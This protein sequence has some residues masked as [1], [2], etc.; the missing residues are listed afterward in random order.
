[1]GPAVLITLG[2]LFL[3]SQVG[4]SYWLNF[5]RTWPALLIVIGLVSFLKHSASAAGHVP[6]EYRGAPA[7]PAWAARPV[8]PG[9]GGN[10]CAGGDALPHPTR[11]KPVGCAVPA[12]SG[13]HGGTPWLAPIRRNLL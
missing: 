3:L 1:M 11:R 5:D 12:G 4:S 6:R 10:E 13:R 7:P 2:V 8:Q 9:H